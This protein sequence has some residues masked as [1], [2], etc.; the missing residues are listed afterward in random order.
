MLYEVRICTV[1]LLTLADNRAELVALMGAL[2][3]ARDCN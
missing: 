3:L 2:K 1:S